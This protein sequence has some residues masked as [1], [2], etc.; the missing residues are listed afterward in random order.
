[1]KYKCVIFDCD[2]VLVDSEAIASSVIIELAANYDAVF[3]LDYALKHFTGTSI[4]FV[5]KHIEENFNVTLPTS[6]ETE[7]R[8]RSTIAFNNSL[9]AIEDV[10]NVIQYLSVPICVASN[11]PL[12]KMKENLKNTGLLSYFNNHLYSAYDLGKWKPDP[13]LFLHAAKEMGYQPSECLVIE[14]SLAGVKAA[15]AG[16]FDCYAFSNNHKDEAFKK[17][18]VNVFYSMNELKRIL[19]TLD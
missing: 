5:M 8:K 4:G 7:Y 10:E 17:E 9:V 6:F 12:P 14:D 13:S 1:M 16:G 15:K 18:K 19:E 2:G 11:G 3:S